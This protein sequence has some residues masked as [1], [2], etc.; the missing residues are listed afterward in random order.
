VV[1]VKLNHGLL[2]DLTYVL[3]FV[4]ADL[5]RIFNCGI[6]LAVKFHQDTTTIPTLS[7]LTTLI[8]G[9]NLELKLQQ[10]E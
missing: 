1:V 8:V 3:S 7:L 4:V 6:D 5:L 9:E 2:F 10:R